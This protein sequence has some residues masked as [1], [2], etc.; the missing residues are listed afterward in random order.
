MITLQLTEIIISLVTTNYNL[1]HAGLKSNHPEE[2][3]SHYYFSPLMLVSSL[4]VADNS[5]APCPF[6]G[7]YTLAP[8]PAAALL[9]PSLG[10]GAGCST[11]MQV[12][13]LLCCENLQKLPANVID[14]SRFSIGNSRNTAAERR[15]QS[16]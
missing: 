11:Y 7:S 8:A 14:T 16:G 15:Q 13:C 3:Y 10:A 12:C 4:L 5:S 9:Q 1:C 2:A 6:S